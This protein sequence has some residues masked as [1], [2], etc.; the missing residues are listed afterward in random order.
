[1]PKTRKAQKGGGE[2][3]N[4]EYSHEPHM[5]FLSVH[6]REMSLLHC[7]GGGGEAQSKKSISFIC[8]TK[9]K[10]GNSLKSHCL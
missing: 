4:M 7:K 5:I 9:E 8:S 6:L 1:M 3:L 2:P 10:E